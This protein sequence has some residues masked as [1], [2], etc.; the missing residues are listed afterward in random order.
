M[1]TKI[2][3]CCG[4]RRMMAEAKYGVAN[5]W[6]NRPL[7]QCHMLN[8][9]CYTNV[10]TEIVKGDVPILI[11]VVPCIMLNSEINPTRCNN[12]VYSS[13]WLYSTCL[14]RQFHPSSG[15]HTLYMASGR[16][17]Y[18]CCNFVSIIVQR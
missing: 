5:D 2:S 9:S 4:I 11:F 16:Q 13:Q 7:K 3:S 12:C 14:G 8:L 1:V 10:H 6:I 15:V 18:L 17:V